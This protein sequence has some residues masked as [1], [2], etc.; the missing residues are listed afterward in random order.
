LPDDFATAGREL[1]GADS[2]DQWGGNNQWGGNP[3]GNQ[4]GGN[5]WGGSNWNG[6]WGARPNFRGG[7]CPRGVGFGP[8]NAVAFPHLGLLAGTCTLF[9]NGEGPVQICA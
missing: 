4:W 6:A 7:S 8:V 1:L 2:K 5:Q 9:N 3:W